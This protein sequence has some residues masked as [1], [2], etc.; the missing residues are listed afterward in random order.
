MKHRAEESGTFWVIEPQKLT[1]PI[2]QAKIDVSF[3]ELEEADIPQLVTAMNFAN[4]TI[5]RE[6]L[7]QKKRCFILKINQQIATYGW[8]THG[9]E[10]VGELERDFQFYENEAYIWHCGTVEQWRGNRLYSAL[11]SQIIQQLTREGI[12][13]IWIG[14]NRA[15][16]P[17]VKGFV[18]AGFQPVVDVAYRRYF[19]FT[20]FLVSPDQAANIDLIREAYRVFVNNHERRLGR[21]AVGYLSGRV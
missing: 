20:F 10:S 17:S 16:H 4:D 5:I 11:L 3:S 2:C 15:N 9:A 6:R 1:P 8:V 19:R 18:N 13:K 14:A 7:Q 12:I 21:L